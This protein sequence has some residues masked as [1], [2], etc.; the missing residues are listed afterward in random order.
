MDRP[1]PSRTRVAQALL[2]LCL[3]ALTATGCERD[4]ATTLDL[5]GSVVADR[6]ALAA[7]ALLVG[8]PDFEAGF[9]TTATPQAPSAS[10]RGSAGAGSWVRVTEVLVETG[11]TVVSGAPLLRF[12]AAPLEAALAAARADTK[13]ARADVAQI[14]TLLSDVTEGKS[15]ITSKTA[16]INEAITDLTEQRADAQSRLDAAKAALPPPGSTPSTTTPP[17]GTQD[18]A[19]LVRQLEAALKQIDDAI[20]AAQKGLTDL[21]TASTD[22]DTASAALQATRRAADA[23]REAADIAV[24][25]AEVQLDAAT[26]TAPDDGTILEIAPVG[27]TLAGGA[28]AVVLRPSSATRIETYVPADVRRLVDFGSQATIR[29][30]SRPDEVLSGYV[31][32]VDATY[33]FVPT[34]FATKEIHLTRAFRVI[35]EIS[36]DEWIPPGTPVDVS[37]SVR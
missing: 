15:D 7:P 25:I 30:D 35:V 3:S 17:P 13:R 18:P 28:P 12:D 16:E 5:T 37:L 23:M 19:A 11:D 33:E 29:L 34:R 27:E 10:P 9:E 22:L 2:A 20:E 21:Q 26:L 4:P 6:A 24:T 14:D 32:R 8:A 1:Y 31:Q 36:G